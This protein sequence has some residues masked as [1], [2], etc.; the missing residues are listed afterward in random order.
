MPA[1]PLDPPSDPALAQLVVTP[2][3]VTFD[4]G[5]AVDLEVQGL[6]NDGNDVDIADRLSFTSDDDAI[7]TVDDDGLV[8]A[9]AVGQV[10]VTARVGLIAREVPVEV[11][12][13]A[14]PEGLSYDSPIIVTA[15]E[16]M[17]PVAPTSTGGTILTYSAE[18]LPRGLVIDERTG[19]ISGVPTVPQLL[20]D[21]VVTGVNGS[22]STS[23][24]FE[25]EVRCDRD[26]AP[27]D[28]DDRP[29]SAFDDENDDGIDGMACGPVFVSPLGD[30]N[31]SGLREA[32]L[33]TLGAA[34]AMAS[35]LEP[36]RDVYMAAGDYVG[37]IALASGVSLY[38]GYD[39]PT[40]SRAAANTTRIEG[41]RIAVTADALQD[42]VELALLEIVA[43]DS[44]VEGEPSIGIF[45]VSNEALITLTDV[46]VQAG[47]G[48]DG[49]NGADG[50][51]QPEDGPDGVSGGGG[52]EGSTAITCAAC[53]Q[54]SPGPEVFTFVIGG[55]GGA[56][57]VPGLGAVDGQPGEDGE[58][59]ALGG[60]AG[61]YVVSADPFL[62]D[63]LTGN[64]G[65]P[66]VD[67]GDGLGG[68]SGLDGEDGVSGSDGEG[69]GGGGGGAGYDSL[70]DDFGGAGGAGG[71]GARGGLSG[72]GGTRGGGSFGVV[73]ID[74]D[75]V[76][77]G[78]QLVAGAGGN[79]GN[80]G[81]GALGGAGGEPGPGSLGFDS[82]GNGGA[83]GKGGD[84][85]DGGHG[86]GGGGGAS[87]ALLLDDDTRVALTATT[88]LTGQAGQ[89]GNGP[90]NIGNAG[91]VAQQLEG[92]L[93]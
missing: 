18:D 50:G 31:A 38:G 90:G 57:G 85:G 19:V 16:A 86:G 30:D 28:D 72:G 82:S 91:V 47:A 37:P 78:A 76:S 46:V 20:G 53:A 22:G 2:A 93:P 92:A 55:N 25:V 65:D 24:T 6:D 21:V 41:G 51:A 7:A 36:P 87:V 23:T 42:D 66:G 14:P 5:A 61:L 33:L 63:G 77:N 64:D 11:V 40:F 58:A 69:G 39:A 49:E 45:V 67:G 80:G 74:S 83:G 52:C 81:A 71:A 9:V 12:V 62:M 13:A 4:I 56:G 84:G 60:L 70:C 59:G 15:G 8:T 73:V 88:L 26:I 32:P 79:G 48:S 29:D 27:N 35:S 68:L 3:S 44:L 89:G 17:T 54:P 43:E 75:V 1:D 34:L 10:V